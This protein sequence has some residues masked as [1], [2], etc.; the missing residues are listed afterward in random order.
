MIQ[1]IKDLYVG[2]QQDYEYKV[3]GKDNWAVI[4]ACKEPYHRRLL[5]YTGR[6]AP[7]D[8]P[9]YLIAER[10]DRLFLNLVDANTPNYIPKEI[11]DKALE[12][13]AQKLR[14]NK[15][16]LVHCNQGMSR[17]PTIAFLY[18]ANTSYFTTSDFLEAEQQFRELYPFY[19]PGNGIHQFAIQNWPN[20]LK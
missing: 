16:V 5:G 13:I 4:H 2:S 7:K 1:V 6:R 19:E 18:L 12:Y 14:E 20:Y 17:S 8:H 3:K 9:E 11:I 15:K 10:D